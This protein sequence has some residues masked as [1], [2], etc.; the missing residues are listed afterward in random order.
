MPDR[1]SEPASYRIRVKAQEKAN[2]SAPADPSPCNRDA[3][4]LP[5]FTDEKDELGSYLLCF[6]RCVEN[7]SWEK[8]TW[9]VKLSALLTERAMEVYTRMS[10]TDGN[11]YAS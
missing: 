9:A 5:A 7:A 8:N 11:D 3:K 1:P 2:T 6:E 10:D 4:K